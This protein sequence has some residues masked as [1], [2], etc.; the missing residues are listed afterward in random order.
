MLIWLVGILFPYIFL[1]FWPQILKPDPRVF[2]VNI[3][4]DLVFWIQFLYRIVYILATNVRPN[5]MVF[6]R[7][8]IF[9]NFDL[10]PG[11]IIFIQQ[12]LRFGNKYKRRIK[13]YFLRAQIFIILICQLAILF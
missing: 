3:N 12:S 2:S 8:Q 4:F 13:L 9:N 5:P 10:D 1:K 7:I 6:L 11:D